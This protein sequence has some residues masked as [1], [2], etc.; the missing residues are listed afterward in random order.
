MNDCFCGCTNLEYADLS[1]L[2]LRNNRCF[3]NFF[4]GDKKL[5]VVKFPS[6]SFS[7]IYWYYRMFYGC[8]SLTSIDMSN[9]HNTNGEYFYE[10]FYGCVNLKE[11][12]L[13]GFNKAYYGYSKYDMFI[14]VPKDAKITIHNNFYRGITEQL[15]D[16]SNK[17]INN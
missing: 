16:F 4:K 3:M 2:D 9:V 6:E 10:M 7:N 17:K 11:I 13:G 5:K 12:N 14:N 15:K 1:N 8:E